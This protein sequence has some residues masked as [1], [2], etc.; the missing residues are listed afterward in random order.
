MPDLKFALIGAVDGSGPCWFVT[1]Q[2]GEPPE[3]IEVPES[4]V[5]S[6][7]ALHLRRDGEP[8]TEQDFNQDSRPFAEK[9][10]N[11]LQEGSDLSH[12]A[13]LAIVGD[14]L[15]DLATMRGGFVGF[16]TG[17]VGDKLQELNVFDNG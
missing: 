9:I 1:M 13:P 5:A 2:P 3:V 8:L 7:L 6:L 12:Q 4:T 15:A 11:Q 17:P 16:E 14:R 10:L